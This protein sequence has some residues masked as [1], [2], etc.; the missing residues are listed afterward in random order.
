[1][2]KNIIDL[3]YKLIQILSA[4]RFVLHEIQNVFDTVIIHFK[5]IYRY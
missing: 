1:M 4:Q 2:V 3:S 5:F